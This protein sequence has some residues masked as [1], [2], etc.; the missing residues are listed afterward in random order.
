VVTLCEIGQYSE[1]EPE[2]RYDESVSLGVETQ[3]GQVGHVSVSDVGQKL[4]V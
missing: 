3:V 1:P 4:K 2:S